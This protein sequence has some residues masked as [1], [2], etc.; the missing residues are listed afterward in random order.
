MKTVRYL[1]IFLVFLAALSFFA[2]VTVVTAR[3]QTEDN[4]IFQG[5]VLD[6]TGNPVAGAEVFFYASS[7]VRRPAD[8]IAPPATESGEFRITLPPGSYWVVARLRKGEE[9][10]GPLLAGDK[11]SGAPLEIELFPGE[12]VEEDFVVVDLK[13]AS[14]LAKKYDADFLRVEGKLLSAGGQP[15]AMMFA[16]ANREPVVKKIPDYISEWTDESGKYTLFLPE[17]TYHFG[18]SRELPIGVESMVLKK[19][20]IDSSTKNNDIVLDE[21]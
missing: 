16:F 19:V 3:A 13:E 21:K 9:R 7:N 14:Q 17:G 20:T 12:T 2:N 15:L 1:N 11:H 8:F 10:F 4:A 6:V 18:L 5:Q